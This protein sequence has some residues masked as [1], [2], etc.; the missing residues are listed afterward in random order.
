MFTIDQVVA[1]HYPGLNARRMSGPIITS[2]Q[3]RLLDERA[4]FYFAEEY[5]HLHGSEFFEQ[6][7]VS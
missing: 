3:W 6:V 2:L 5:P 7:F 4:F 1:K